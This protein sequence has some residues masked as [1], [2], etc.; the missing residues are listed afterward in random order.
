[1]FL[2][3]SP[4]NRVRIAADY[5]YIKTKMIVS[6]TTLFLLYLGRGRFFF[7]LSKLKSTVERLK[8]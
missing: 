5:F 3:P 8:I 6:S 7:S 1:M 2:H 4:H